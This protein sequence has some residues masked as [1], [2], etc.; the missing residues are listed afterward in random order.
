MTIQPDPIALYGAMD[1]AASSSEFVVDP[2]HG[3]LHAE[4]G[5]A[6]AEG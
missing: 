3:G 1:R 2:D 6:G 4:L 5:L